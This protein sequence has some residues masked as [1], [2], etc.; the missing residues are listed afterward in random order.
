MER[1]L[2]NPEL[3]TTEAL[4]TIAREFYAQG[5]PAPDIEE[6]NNS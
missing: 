5:M 4:T 3:N 2:D 1:V 6:E